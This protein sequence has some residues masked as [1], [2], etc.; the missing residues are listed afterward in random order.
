[1]GTTRGAI[2]GF[3]LDGLWESLREVSQLVSKNGFRFSE[4]LRVHVDLDRSVLAVASPPDVDVSCSAL[5]YNGEVDAS[6]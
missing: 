6:R 3:A 1:V 4:L 2:T 5:S